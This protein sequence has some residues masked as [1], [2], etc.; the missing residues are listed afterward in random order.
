MKR[1]ERNWR[2]VGSDQK[3]PLNGGG[4]LGD[5]I[6]ILDR[7]FCLILC[8]EGEAMDSLASKM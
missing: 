7:C 2:P 4:A 8:L 5:R 6:M 1:P 3:D